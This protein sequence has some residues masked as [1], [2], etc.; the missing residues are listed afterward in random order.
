MITCYNSSRKR[1]QW[2]V[3]NIGFLLYCL[4]RWYQ[5]IP[6]LNESSIQVSRPRRS[7]PHSLFYKRP[8]RRIRYYQKR[9]VSQMKSTKHRLLSYLPVTHTLRHFIPHWPAYICVLG[10]S[11]ELINKDVNQSSGRLELRF[12]HLQAGCTMVQSCSGSSG[13]CERRVT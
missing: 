5:K 11:R 6:V 3:W 8:A 12:S 7:I 2:P 1:I 13:K 10:P 4:V 9:W